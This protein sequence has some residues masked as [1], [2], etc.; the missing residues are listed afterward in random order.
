M[1]SIFILVQMMLNQ[2][3]ACAQKFVRAMKQYLGCAHYVVVW[4]VD[5]TMG[6]D[7]LDWQIKNK[8]IFS[9]HHTPSFII[10]SLPSVGL[11]NQPAYHPYGTWF[12]FH[13]LHL[14]SVIFLAHF[15]CAPIRAPYM[16]HFAPV[17]S[18]TRSAGPSI[19]STR[20]RFVGNFPYRRVDIFLAS[21]WAEGWFFRRKI[22]ACVWNPNFDTVDLRVKVV[23]IVD[24]REVCTFRFYVL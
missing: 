15:G 16:G 18:R 14:H 8:H 1:L 2:Y 19:F 24:N 10:F 5:W 21:V 6:C 4:H 12:F 23:L 11:I 3:I 7:G 13:L 20:L 17:T 22:D 9:L